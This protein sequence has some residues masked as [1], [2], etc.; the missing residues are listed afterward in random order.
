MSYDEWERQ[1]GDN[2]VAFISDLLA[3]I[4]NKSTKLFVLHRHFKI[5]AHLLGIYGRFFAGLLCVITMG[6]LLIR[7]HWFLN[8]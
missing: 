8:H 3:N 5:I 2:I 4:Q 6:D 1:K 7:P